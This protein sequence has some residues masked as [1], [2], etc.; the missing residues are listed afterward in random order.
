[1]G[2]IIPPIVNGYFKR[3]GNDAD[4]KIRATVSTERREALDLKKSIEDF[5]SLFEPGIEIAI[6]LEFEESEA[7]GF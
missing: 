4:Q 3:H 6:T 2:K 7:I 1:V 5:R